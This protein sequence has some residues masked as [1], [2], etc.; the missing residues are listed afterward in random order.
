MR[1]TM[2]E[3]ANDHYSITPILHHSRLSDYWLLN[4]VAGVSR[5]RFFEE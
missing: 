4:I 5:A 3:P 1:L 2:G